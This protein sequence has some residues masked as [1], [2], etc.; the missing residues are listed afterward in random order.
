[1]TLGELIRNAR[2]RMSMTQEQLAKFVGVRRASVSQWESGKTG[3]TRKHIP[4]LAAALRLDQS[5]FNPLLKESIK[6]LNTVD[7]GK[8]IPLLTL[9]DVTLYM[10]GIGSDEV[11]N[12]IAIDAETSD[13]AMAILILDDS[14]APEFHPSDVVIVDTTEVPV[15]GDCVLVAFA[16]R[17]ALLRRFIARGHDSHGRR[18]FDLVPVNP[19]HVTI[20]VTEERDNA[21]L[22]GPVIE[23]RRKRR[24]KGSQLLLT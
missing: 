5:S 13:A 11:E 12:T 15:D 6:R 2:E 10:R 17:K 3:P 18:V 16:D 22:V 20:T 9:G 19:N 8:S 14:M 4:K 7:S 23:H 1:M 21:Q 24:A